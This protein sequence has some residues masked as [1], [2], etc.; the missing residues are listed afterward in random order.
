MQERNL[1]TLPGIPV[2]LVILAAMAGIG[3]SI[4]GGGPLIWLLAKI[5]AL[6]VLLVAIFG[7]FVVQ[8]NQASVVLLFGRYVGTVREN[9][10]RW[11]NP[12]YS[13]KVVTLRVRNFESSKLKVNDL[14]GNPIEIA[15]IVVW[16]V[17]DTAQAVFDDIRVLWQTRI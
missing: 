13:V 5:L 1:N 15:A 11:A 12:F 2:L 14:E 3:A 17:V 7:L 4:P 9:G 16:Q 10:L 6:V 8:P